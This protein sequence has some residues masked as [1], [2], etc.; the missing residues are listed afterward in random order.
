ME[1]F[2]AKLQ[3]VG[4]LEYSQTSLRRP[5]AGHKKS[6][7]LRGVVALERDVKKACLL[8]KQNK[9]TVYREISKI[10]VAI[11]CG[12]LQCHNF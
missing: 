9:F 12:A 7:R 5:P 6:G 1:F 4:N 2:I 10:L 3:N 8:K 11:F